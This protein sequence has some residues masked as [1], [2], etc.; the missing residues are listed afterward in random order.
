M[1][2]W[3]GRSLRGFWVRAQQYEI[4]QVVA[5]PGLFL[6]QQKTTNPRVVQPT[7]SWAL[8]NQSFI[9]Q[10]NATQMG[11]H[12]NLIEDF[13]FQDSLFPDDPSLWHG[14]KNQAPPPIPLRTGQLSPPCICKNFWN[15]GVQYIPGGTQWVTSFI[16]WSNVHL[17]LFFYSKVSL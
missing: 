7:E 9:N 16:Y 11:L 6:L 2:S 4:I 12:D 5:L 13:F 8:L 10:E 17:M 3:L 1:S 15:S 14:D